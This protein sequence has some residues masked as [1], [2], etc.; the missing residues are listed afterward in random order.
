MNQNEFYK[1]QAKT[2]GEL[3]KHYGYGHLTPVPSPTNYDLAIQL[4]K[5]QGE[6]KEKHLSK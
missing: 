2:L 6:K 1:Q 4:M 3:F 5:R